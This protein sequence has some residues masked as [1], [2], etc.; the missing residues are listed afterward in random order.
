MPINAYQRKRDIRS[1]FVPIGPSIAYV[2]LT[3]GQYALIDADMAGLIGERNWFAHWNK[4]SQSF[5][6]EYS[7]AGKTIGLHRIICS[8]IAPTVDH[9]NRNS[10]DNRRSNLRIATHRQ[11]ITNASAKKNSKTGMKGVDLDRNTG[12]YRARISI[13]GSRMSLGLFLTP[14]EAS[15]AYQAAA[16]AHHGEFAGF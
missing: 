10:L 12:K 8:E 5:Y 4:D 3:Q 9:I 6:A 14:E 2:P 15:M 7:N 16:I 1:I 11:N 13:D